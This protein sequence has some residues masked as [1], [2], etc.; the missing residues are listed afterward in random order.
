MIT[1]LL[2]KEIIE[3]R[4]SNPSTTINTIPTN[5][6]QTRKRRIQQNDLISQKYQEEESEK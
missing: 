5:E 4:F 6:I 1:K 2:K 3:I